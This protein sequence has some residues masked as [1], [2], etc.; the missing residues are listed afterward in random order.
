MFTYNAK[1]FRLTLKETGSIN[2]VDDDLK[3]SERSLPRGEDSVLLRKRPLLEKD[4]YGK[5]ITEE[6]SETGRVR[7]I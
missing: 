2:T 3:S 5:T 6:K 7:H 1:I 4:G